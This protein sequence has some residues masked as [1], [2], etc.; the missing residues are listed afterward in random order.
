MCKWQEIGTA[1]KDGTKIVGLTPYGVEVVRFNVEKEKI[2]GDY[3]VRYSS[4]WVGLEQDSHCFQAA[5]YSH[6]KP[7]K[8]QHQPTHWMPLPTPPS[9]HQAS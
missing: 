7:R 9:G 5:Q 4:G 1:P 3:V 2:D 6:R 8:A